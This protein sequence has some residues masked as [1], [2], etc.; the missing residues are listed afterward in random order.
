MLY[1][2]CLRSIPF[3][4]IS[5]PTKSKANISV[6]V[7]FV[8]T[9]NFDE[10]CTIIN[11]WACCRSGLKIVLRTT[12]PFTVRNSF[13]PTQSEKVCESQKENQFSSTLVTLFIRDYPSRYKGPKTSLMN[14]LNYIVILLIGQIVHYDLVVSSFLDFTN[15]SVKICYEFLMQY[16]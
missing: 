15:W 4:N 2:N 12:V 9:S 6:R 8:K 3:L 7:G 1:P 16:F 13:M 10:T 14:L 5:L 11:G